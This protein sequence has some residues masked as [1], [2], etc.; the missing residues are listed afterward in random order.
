MA[1]SRSQIIGLLAVLALAP[2]TY[3]LLG[4]SQI[5]VWASLVCVVLIT[6]SLFWMFGPAEESAAGH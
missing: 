3:Y 4:T 1:L 6:A 5:I 2:V